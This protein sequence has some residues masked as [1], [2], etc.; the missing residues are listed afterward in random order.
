LD[1]AQLNFQSDIKPPQYNYTWVAWANSQAHLP[2][3]GED[4]KWK[5]RGK[6]KEK[7]KE[8]CLYILA[9]CLDLGVVVARVKPQNHCP[10][11]Q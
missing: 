1:I 3:H 8:N 9:K 2:N 6:K 7:M 10:R 11:K 4:E 5:G